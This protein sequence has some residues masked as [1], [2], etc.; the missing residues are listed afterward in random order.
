V[1]REALRKLIDGMF[2]GALPARSDAIAADNF[3]G[4]R[5]L[6]VEDNTVN[7]M[8]ATT[9]LQAAGCIVEVAGNGREALERLERNRYQLVLMDC[10]MPEMDGYAATTEWRRRERASGAHQPIV[11]LTANAMEGDRERCVAA[12][13]DDYLAKPFRREQML[14]ML[15]RYL[16]CEEPATPVHPAPAEAPAA[17]DF[18]PKALDN[19]RQIE[20]G[21]A[22]GLV[23][24]VLETYIVS[25]REL[26]ESLGRS[27][28][29]GDLKEL[30]RAAHTLKSSSANVGAMALAAL[31]RQL[32]SDAAAQRTESAEDLIH[33]IGIAYAAAV[34]ALEREIPEKHHASV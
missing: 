10:Q 13:M 9:M 23:T 29:A 17:S 28:V 18:D 22:P 25:A 30:H 2:P 24:K 12:G 31:A 1:R 21:G 4:A 3:A 19:L 7:Q 14:A 11:A 27:L 6:L 26:V 5:I 8:V 34:G 16:H 15:R 20:R 33:R 32:E